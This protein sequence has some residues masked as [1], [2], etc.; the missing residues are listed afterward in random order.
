MPEYH[1]EPYITLA[2]VTPH[3]A[4]ISWGGFY[5]RVRGRDGSF[6]LVD[7]SALDKVH[8][9]RRESI[10][11]R[12]EPYGDARVIVYD[13]L[14]G[15][16]AATA[17]TTVANH[18]WLTGLNPDT[19][20]TYKVFVNGEEWAAGERRDWMVA[21]ERQ[22][23]VTA[24]NAYV[25]QFRTHP[26]PSKPYG[27]PF[28]FAVLGDFGTGVRKPSSTNRRQ[29]EVAEALHEA[30]DRYDVRFVLTAGDNIYAGRTLLMIP[31]GD[32]GDEDDDWFFTYY[33]PY[34]YL[35]NRIPVYPSIGNHDSSES[36][37]RD[38]RTQLFDNFY[39]NERIAGEEKSGRSSVGPGLF[40][41]FPF[42][43]DAEFICIDTSKEPEVFGHRLFLHPKHA[44]FLRQTFGVSL[45]STTP[46]RWRIPYCHH[47][48]FSAG[49]LH[50]NTDEMDTLLPLLKQG[51]VRVMF[52][53][54]E[55]NFQHSNHDGIDYFVTGGGGKVRPFPPQQR[56][57]RSAHTLSWSATCHFLLVTIDGPRLTVTPVSERSSSG[58][59]VGVVRKAPD[60]S[61]T[62][63]PI[64][65]FG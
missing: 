18:C 42:G 3:S 2:G 52:S 46:P 43:S 51:G 41:R 55:H 31:M 63:G 7:D 54:H 16:E 20:Y 13:A 14:T 64:E 21:G 23:L 36:E 38:D 49:P 37:V 17:S 8:P 30:V 48:P 25:N 27:R 59:L 26:D 6:K 60:G 22:G 39:I 1:A 47:P 56:H 10:G 11:A 58:D 53:G 19:Q 45:A 61:T 4:L 9:P 32:Q 65:L 15:A 28:T 62:D 29:R 5:F 12:S 57:M 35:L 40:Y 44:D 50:L 33:Q 24:G 34:R